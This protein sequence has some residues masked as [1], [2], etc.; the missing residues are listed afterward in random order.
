MNVQVM[1]S[2]LDH[3]I[4]VRKDFLHISDLSP[5]EIQDLLD[6]AISLKKEYF[7]GGNPPVLK[8]KVLGIFTKSQFYSNEK[9]N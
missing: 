9:S 7:N 2:T 4:A 6:L 1:Q 3:D 8:G 5:A